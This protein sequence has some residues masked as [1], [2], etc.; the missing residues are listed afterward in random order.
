[1]FEPIESGIDYASTIIMLSTTYGI[2][3]N[4]ILLLKL[5]GKLKFIIIYI[6]FIFRIMF[7]LSLAL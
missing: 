4:V 3:Y 7:L 5:C 2:I 6:L 1:M